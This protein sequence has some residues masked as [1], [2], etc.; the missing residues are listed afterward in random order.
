MP[1]SRALVAVLAVAGALALAA[2]TPGALGDDDAPSTSPTPTPAPP[3]S[4]A[5]ADPDP[6]GF[7]PAPSEAPV[8][9]P[10]DGDLDL[11]CGDLLTPQQVYDFNPEMLATDAPTGGLPAGFATIVEVGGI[12]C[13]WQHA[14]SGDVLLV[15][16][17]SVEATEGHDGWDCTPVTCADAVDGDTYVLVG[18]LYFEG[19]EDQGRE[20]A[21]LVADNVG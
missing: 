14:T 15:G 7:D 2:C 19:A 5:P 1:R 6:S 16:V 18:S 11:A 20:L 21:R 10:V 17:A 3:P 13:A 9:G 4:D 8:V 12:V